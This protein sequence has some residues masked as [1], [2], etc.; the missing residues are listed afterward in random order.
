MI[1]DVIEAVDELRRRLQET[2]ETEEPRI[3]PSTDEQVQI[4][5]GAFAQPTPSDDLELDPFFVATNLSIE[6]PSPDDLAS[7]EETGIDILAFYVSFHFG[8]DWGIYIRE[9]GLYLVAWFLQGPYDPVYRLQQAF[10]CL[11]RHEYFHFLTDVAV[12]TVELS[13]HDWLYVPYLRA[14]KGGTPPWNL[15]EEAMANAYALGGFAGSALI[16]D[17]ERFMGTQPPGYRDHASFRVRGGRLK[18]GMPS[19][20]SDAISAGGMPALPMPLGPLLFDRAG[21]VV[22]VDDVPVYLI[23]DPARSSGQTF[24]LIT[25]IPTLRQTERFSKDLARL[26]EAIRTKWAKA[27]Q[28]LAITARSRSLNFEK[29]KNCDTVFS[30]RIDRGIRATI[31]Q[32]PSGEWEALRIGTHDYVYASTPC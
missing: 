10:R 4:L 7:V 3:R 20:L 12:T 21:Q 1:Q 29:L 2:D 19:L 14:A 5:H 22:R 25:S 26:P 9:R 16:P 28:V 23:R 30:I 13:S 17:F 11:H 27:Q 18:Q 15:Q 24:H 31:R 6:Q 8:R 32:S